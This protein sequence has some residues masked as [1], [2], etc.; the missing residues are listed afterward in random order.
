MAKLTLSEELVK[1]QEELSVIEGK[2]EKFITPDLIDQR[3]ILKKQVENLKKM[4]ESGEK[5][6]EPA[7]EQNGGKG[8]KFGKKP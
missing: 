5:A 3:N 7:A 8:G 2:L 4:I 6:P 1:A